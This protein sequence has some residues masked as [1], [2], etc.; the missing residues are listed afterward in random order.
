MFYNLN[1]TYHLRFVTAATHNTF[2]GPSIGLMFKALFYQ[3]Y[4]SPKHS[5]PCQREPLLYSFSS[6]LTLQVA[7]GWR[8]ESA[9]GETVWI[10]HG[11]GLRSVPGKGKV[12]PSLGFEFPLHQSDE[13]WV[14]SWKQAAGKVQWLI[15]R[16]GCLSGFV[17]SSSKRTYPKCAC[18]LPSEHSLQ[19]ILGLC[20]VGEGGGGLWAQSHHQ[21]LTH[22][23]ITTTILAFM[24]AKYFSS[25]SP[26]SIAFCRCHPSD[27]K[28]TR[29]GVC[30][31]SLP[32]IYPSQN[33]TR[34]W[35]ELCNVSNDHN[36]TRK[37]CPHPSFNTFNK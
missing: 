25:P 29:Q 19:D 8:W 22:I 32:C 30:T 1:P 3:R 33:L 35:V 37:Q 9:T 7:A 28:A 18:Q 5:L 15:L 21:Y 2:S 16:N 27:K 26:S 17:S 34:N 6:H 11:S 10:K 20:E 4:K 36:T 24:R 23:P 12:S 31:S 13:I 14:W